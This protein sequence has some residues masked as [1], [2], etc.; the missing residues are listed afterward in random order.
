M[1]KAQSLHCDLTVEVIKANAIF[2]NFYSKYGF[3]CVNELLHQL[4][5]QIALQLKF[6]AKS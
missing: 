6:T 1:D 2:R 4:T 3:E 5:E